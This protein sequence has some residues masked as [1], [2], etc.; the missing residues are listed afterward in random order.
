MK[1]KFSQKIFEKFSNVKFDENPYGRNRIIP[2]GEAD[3]WTEKETHMKRLIV[4]FNSFGDAP[5]FVF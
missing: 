5:N 1:N 2:C 4:A 3:G